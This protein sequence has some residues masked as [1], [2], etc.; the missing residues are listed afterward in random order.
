MVNASLIARANFP[1]YIFYVQDDTTEAS[2]RQR[3]IGKA[4]NTRGL[5]KTGDRKFAEIAPPAPADAGEAFG[6]DDRALGLAC[7]LFQPCRQI[8]R[9]PDAGEVEPVAAA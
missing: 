3:F 2:H 6:S 9:R 8:H 7:D 5:R 1:I 4:I